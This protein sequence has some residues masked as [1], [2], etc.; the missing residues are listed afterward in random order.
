MLQLSTMGQHAMLLRTP[1]PVMPG[2]GIIYWNLQ[3]GMLTGLAS[4]FT[5]LGEEGL[6]I[7][8]WDPLS[9]CKLDLLKCTMPEMEHTR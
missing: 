4:Y 5:F 2:K 3:W 7:L 9:C 1:S 8:H 6:L